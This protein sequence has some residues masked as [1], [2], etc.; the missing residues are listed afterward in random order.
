MQRTTVAIAALFL[1]TASSL[2]PRP[3]FFAAVTSNAA[4]ECGSWRITET[5]AGL[6]ITQRAAPFLP[7]VVRDCDPFPAAQ[8][9]LHETGDTCGSYANT[10]SAQLAVAQWPDFCLGVRETSGSVGVYKCDDASAARKWAYK[11]DDGTVWARA[12]DGTGVAACLSTRTWA[13]TAANY[14]SSRAK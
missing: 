7:L 12:G 11:D 3:M 1:A 14:S 9:I 10:S 13:H 6:T 8:V 4:D 2:S 5:A